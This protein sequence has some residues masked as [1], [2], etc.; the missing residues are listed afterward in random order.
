MKQT[1]DQQCSVLNWAQV[2]DEAQEHCTVKSI[3]LC[4][5]LGRC[6]V[7]VCSLRHFKTQ[8][9]FLPVLVQPLIILRDLHKHMRSISTEWLLFFSSPLTYW[10]AITFRLSSRGFEPLPMLS[11]SLSRTVHGLLIQSGCLHKAW[12]QQHLLQSCCRHLLIQGSAACWKWW[13]PTLLLS[14]SLIRLDIFIQH[15]S[16]CQLTGNIL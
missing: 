15:Q 2:C 7:T 5:F 13:L 12:Q 4:Y 11:Q 8:L 3:G 14:H 16:G 9:L 1:W 6:S 10:G